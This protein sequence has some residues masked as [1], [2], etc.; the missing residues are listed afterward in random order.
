MAQAWL[1]YTK[2]LEMFTQRNMMIAEAFGHGGQRKT[3][4]EKRGER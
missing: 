4:R 1:S 3:K 2:I